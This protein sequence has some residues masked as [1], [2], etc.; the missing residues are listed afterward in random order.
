MSGETQLRQ[1]GQFLSTH[2]RLLQSLTADDDRYNFYHTIGKPDSLKC[3]PI[4]LEVNRLEN[5]HLFQL[6]N[7]TNTVLNKIVCV[8]AQLCAEVRE[9]RQQSD[10]L[11]LRFLFVDSKLCGENGEDLAPNTLI[12]RISELLKFFCDIQY[13]VQRCV[14]VGSEIL[15]QLAAFFGGE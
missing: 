14:V 10:K 7:T 8:F 6:A 12:I 15:R 1:F 2:D 5:L 9:L 13:L 4:N 11:Q 3:G